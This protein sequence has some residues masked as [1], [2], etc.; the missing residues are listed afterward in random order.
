MHS[1]N[2]AAKRKVIAIIA[3]LAIAAAAIAWI[4]PTLDE[5]SAIATAIQWGRLAPIPKDATRVHAYRNE[6]F[7]WSRVWVTF[8]AS[9]A[10]IDAFLKSSPGLKGVT[11]EVFTPKHMYLPHSLKPADLDWSNNKYFLDN[12]PRQFHLS[13]F[14]P[15]IKKRGRLY[16]MSTTDD[17]EMGWIAIDDAH[18]VVSIDMDSE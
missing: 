2:Q 6:A 16:E 1:F 9:P 4:K 5:R 7:T 13:W 17:V 18:N 12:E 3:V 15:T 11:P 10:E 8:H 14:D